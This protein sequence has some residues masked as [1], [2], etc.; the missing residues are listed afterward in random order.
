MEVPTS[1]LTT[2]IDAWLDAYGEP[3]EARRGA[4]I[5]Q[6]WAPAGTLAD[7]PL[8]GTGHAEIS[9]LA[10]AALQKF[11]GNRFRR[12]SGVDAHRGYAR[13]SWALVGPDGQ[14]AVEGMDVAQVDGDGKLLRVA[15][16]FG[17]LPAL[18]A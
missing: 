3:D 12:T 7:P 11:P 9:G 10:A 8:E 2:T 18:A 1:D 4:L 14:V 17:D 16:F 6:V 13:Y 5:A 15:G